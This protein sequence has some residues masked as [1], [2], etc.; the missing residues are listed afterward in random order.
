MGP[1]VILYNW[2]N[3]QLHYCV[4]CSFSGF[5]SCIWPG[6]HPATGATQ[7]NPDVGTTIACYTWRIFHNY[8]YGSADG[9]I[10]LLR[11]LVVHAALDRQLFPN[12]VYF[13]H[14]ELIFRFTWNPTFSI[15]VQIWFFGTWYALL[16]FIFGFLDGCYL[17]F[18]LLRVF[19]LI[20][21]NCEKTM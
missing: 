17:I 9:R 15:S 1:K 18:H 2:C 16:V 8:W 12:K 7:Y 21:Q 14:L 6:L 4:R 19:V 5:C 10:S 13:N 20:F 3:G 11:L